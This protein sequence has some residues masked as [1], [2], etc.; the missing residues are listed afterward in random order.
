MHSCQSYQRNGLWSLSWSD[1]RRNGR[2]F[3]WSIADISEGSPIWACPLLCL[4]Q[5]R[6][7]YPP[8]NGNFC[9]LTKYWVSQLVSEIHQH[10]PAQVQC[11]NH[12]WMSYSCCL[13]I[14]Q[15]LWIPK[16]QTIVS[17]DHS[18]TGCSFLCLLPIPEQSLQVPIIGAFLSSLEQACNCISYRQTI[19]LEFR[20]CEDWLPSV[21]MTCT[22][23]AQPPIVRCTLNMYSGV[24]IVMLCTG[25]R[26]YTTYQYAEYR[27]VSTVVRAVLGE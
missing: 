11:L 8:S 1:G 24:G 10:L 3:S 13:S 9:N 4:P 20:V 2:D 21:L 7:D 15:Y 6:K 17:Q 5:H 19:V 23:C 22:R 12:A 25:P 27:T 14:A 26:Q 16:L 18:L